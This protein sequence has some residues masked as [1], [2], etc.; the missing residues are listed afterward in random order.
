MGLRRHRAHLSSCIRRCG[1]PRQRWPGSVCPGPASWRCPGWLL[2]PGTTP[3]MGTATLDL[4]RKTAKERNSDGGCGEASALAGSAMVRDG[5]SP[6]AGG[7]GAQRATPSP[8]TPTPVWGNPWRGRSGR[9]AQWEAAATSNA[10][11]LG[12]TVLGKVKCPDNRRVHGWEQ[13]RSEGVSLQEEASLAL[14]WAGTLPQVTYTCKEASSRHSH[15]PA[16]ETPST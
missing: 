5:C 14:S 6:A 3:T 9:A 11:P 10:A 16:P 8:H 12:W 2:W 4:S 13:Q 1:P 15:L 7:P